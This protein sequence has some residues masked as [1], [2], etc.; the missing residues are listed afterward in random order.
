MSAEVNEKLDH[1]SEM[2][3]RKRYIIGGCLFLLVLLIVCALV[4]A[5]S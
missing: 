2:S 5:L 4:F 3:M 1:V